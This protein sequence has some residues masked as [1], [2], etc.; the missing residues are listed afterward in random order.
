MLEVTLGV[1]LRFYVQSS[2]EGESEGGQLLL[3]LP[4]QTM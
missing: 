2:C 4:N 3:L 1:T